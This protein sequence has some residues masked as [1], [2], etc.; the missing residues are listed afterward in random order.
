MRLSKTGYY[1]DFVIYA[2]VLA[3]AVVVTAW[4]N[5]P[6]TTSIWLLTAAIGALSWTLFE[7][8]LHRFVLH[9]IPVFA[10]MHDAHHQEPLAY[11]GTPTW[12]SLGVIAIAVFLPAWALG[13]FAT[14]SALAVGV[15]AGFF[16]YGLVHHAIHYRR[17]RMIARH[18]LLAS[19][20]HSEHH[21]ARQPGNF[22]V[23]TLF[24]DRVFGTVLKTHP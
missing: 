3:T 14:A 23:T 9:Q 6:Y 8:L 2:A 17:P 21:Y 22:G 10:A 24:W 7:Y 15:M 1:A 11:I 12:L 16:W 18:L 20:H 4:R 19:R 5:T 13:S